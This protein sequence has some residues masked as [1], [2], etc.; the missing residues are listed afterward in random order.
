MDLVA[1]AFEIVFE[2]SL[3]VA[4]GLLLLTYLAFT[5]MNKDVRRARLFIMAD[6]VRR[7]LGAFTVG[8]LLI[9]GASILT[10]AGL[11]TAAFIFLVVIFLFLGAIVY[12]S[13]E[14]FLIV[15]PRPSP[16]R[17]LSKALPSRAAPTAPAT[18]PAEE[19]AEGDVH[20]AR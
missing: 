13:L 18:P 17:S 7:F 8:F 5:R 15:R 10:V 14:L 4:G 11:P 2:G 1:L 9:A 6:R 16:L 20:A 3:A 19:S 12:G